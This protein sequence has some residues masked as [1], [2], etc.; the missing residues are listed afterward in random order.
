MR[1][2]ISIAASPP[3]TPQPP[4]DFLHPPAALCSPRGSSHT[5]SESAQT[6]S[7]KPRE[8]LTLI[9]CELIE[10]V[11]DWLIHSQS[12]RTRVS[13]RSGRLLA[14]VFRASVFGGGASWDRWRKDGAP[15]VLCRNAFSKRQVGF[16]IK[17]KVPSSQGFILSSF[18]QI[19]SEFHELHQSVV[20]HQDAPMNKM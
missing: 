9:A 10:G 16:D 17:V 1:H 11:V 12:W 14:H 6:H 5:A 19:F 2:A 18:E 7:L 20:R 13:R 15:R 8:S 4:A 3:H